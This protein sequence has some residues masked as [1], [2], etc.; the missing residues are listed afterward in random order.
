MSK[1]GVI[2]LKQLWEGRMAARQGK[3]PSNPLDWHLEYL[4]IHTLGLGLEQ[5]LQY[6]MQQA[7]S[8]EEFE[9]WIVQTTGGPEPAGVA[10]INARA[11][12]QPYSEEFQAFLAEI[13]AYPDV[14]TPEDLD[15]WHQNGY[16][17]LHDAVAVA[18]RLEA[19]QAVWAAVQASPDDPDSWYKPNR[20]GIMVQTFQ[21]PAF[22]RNRRS[23]RIY[24]AF[25]QVW[26]T[27]DLWM[28]TD[29]CGFNPPERPGFPFQGPDLHWDC[30]IKQP[31][32][33]ATQ[34]ILYLSD[35]MAEQGAF[36][37]VPGF[38]HKCEDWLK[39]LPAGT[40]P[41]QQDLHAL[42]SQPIP[43]RA[44]DLIIWHQALPH[45]SRPNRAE[46]PRIVQYINMSP[47]YQE[48]A[49]EWI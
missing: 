9:D 19:E 35:T 32:P 45:G 3:Q 7:P 20:Q 25:A 28:S 10:R 2:P 44:G 1:L 42:G 18:D 21:H 11:Q 23:R 29:R 38:H 4:T 13:E 41:R 8:F 33:L 6:L 17:I 36:T 34:G 46:R 43:G 37:L 24:K 12:H 30:S 31:V 49:A 47:S 22:E 26:G 48:Y 5:T 16:V 39:S 27:A 14:L 15:F 40:D